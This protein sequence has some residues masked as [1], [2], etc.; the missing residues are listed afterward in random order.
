MTVELIKTEVAKRGITRLCHFTPSRNLV[1]I[2]LDPR[3]ILSTSKLRQD[4]R[5]AFNP[6]DLQRLDGYPDHVCCSIQYPNS[7]YFRRA[8]AMD[9]IFD[10]WVVLM[11]SPASLWKTGTKFCTRN[12]AAQR[13]AGVQAGIEGFTGMFAEET[14]G[15]YGRTFVRQA[16]RPMNATTDEQAEVLVV[17]NVTSDE[18]IGIAVRDESQAKRETLRLKMLAAVI[19]RL[20][21]V[22]E[23]FD[24][25]RLSSCLARGNSIAELEYI[26]E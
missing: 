25:N 3:G 23:F 10:D 13:G 16:L 9:R 6:T 21:I 12:A 14:T 5:A 18:V 24:P 17:D 7:W 19:P 26:P 22:E 11:L 20:Y 15:A 1:H 4:E 8:R 2:A